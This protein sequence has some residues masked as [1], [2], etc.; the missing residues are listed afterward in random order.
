MNI[1]VVVSDPLADTDQVLEHYAVQLTD[2]GRVGNLDAII[3]AVGHNE[4]RDLSGGQL[5]SLCKSDEPAL[6]AD[7]KAL[8]EKTKMEKLGFKVFRL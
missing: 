6:L 5:K 4:Y 1:E 8:Y 3:V 7:L 2:L